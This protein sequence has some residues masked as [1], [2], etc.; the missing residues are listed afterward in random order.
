MCFLLR[1]FHSSEMVPRA[2][3]LQFLQQEWDNI[4]GS[5]NLPH[6]FPVQ[7]LPTVGPGVFT[8]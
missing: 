8:G 4:E 1:E 2:A 6:Q 5:E 3:L 7:L